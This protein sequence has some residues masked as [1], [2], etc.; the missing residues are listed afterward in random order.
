MDAR[1]LGL[2][3]LLLAIIAAMAG[4]IVS[5]VVIAVIASWLGGRSVGPSSIGLAMVAG[6]AAVVDILVISRSISGEVTGWDLLWAGAMT[7]AGGWAVRRLASPSHRG[8]GGRTGTA[9]AG[10]R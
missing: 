7:M 10:Q 5:A 3:A 4:L 6:T 1:D 2:E 8:T 9:D